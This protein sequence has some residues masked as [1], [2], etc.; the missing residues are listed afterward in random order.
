MS[1]SEPVN[2]NRRRVLIA[3][4]AAMGAAGGAA[5]LAPFVQSWSPSAK[6]EAAGAPVQIDTSSIEPGQMITV[7]YRKAP[8]LVVKRTE[9]MLE[10]LPK[11]VSQISDPES[12]QSSQPEYAQNETRSREPG[13]LV[14]S[15]VCTHLGCKPL[16]RPEVG[17][18]DLGGDSWYG[19]FFCPCHGSKYD[20]AGR[21]FKGVPAPLNLP[22]PDYALNGNMLT[23]GEA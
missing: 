7:E 20:L 4:T 1:Q 10:L 19:G 5:L 3:S 12:L 8:V 15:G 22:V 9:E 23:V 6:A 14:V 16:F 11:N 17:A 13:L 18:A 21:V 2:H